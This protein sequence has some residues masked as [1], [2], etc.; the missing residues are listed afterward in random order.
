MLREI[1]QNI[2][3]SYEKGVEKMKRGSR[4]KKAS[5]EKGTGIGKNNEHSKQG[6]RGNRGFSLRDEDEQEMS[7]EQCGKKAKVGMDEKNCGVNLV[8]LASHDW[9]HIDQ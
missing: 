8:D 2:E 6:I 5:G 1:Y 9:P 3:Q 4:K 7:D